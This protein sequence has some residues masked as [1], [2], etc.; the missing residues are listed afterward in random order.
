MK[1]KDKKNTSM[2]RKKKQNWFAAGLLDIPCDNVRG[3]SFH[4]PSRSGSTWCKI[5]T[6]L[7]RI[8]HWLYLLWYYGF[9][10]F[11]ETYIWTTTSIMYVC[12]FAQLCPTLFDPM[13]CS[14]LSSSIHGI[15]QARILE[16]VAIPFS[17]GSSW[18][19][20]QTQV[21]WIAGGFF[22]IWATRE[23]SVIII[24]KNDHLL[25]DYYELIHDLGK[26]WIP[27]GT[28]ENNSGPL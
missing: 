16:S 12:L 11:A 28:E 6:A 15:L 23:I 4:R 8:C 9:S 21:S 22:T 20:D 13:D 5:V 3:V 25:S 27:K 19:R 2:L 24:N 18:P 10:F 7:M 26:T 17:R 1:T 14:L